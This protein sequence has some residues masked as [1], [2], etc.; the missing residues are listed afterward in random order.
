[1][2]S[3]LMIFTHVISLLQTINALALSQSTQSR[4]GPRNF[5][6][7]KR[8]NYFS[9]TALHSE[10]PSPNED[11]DTK[12]TFTPF[13]VSEGLWYIDEYTFEVKYC[14][15]PSTPE[16]DRYAIPLP[17]YYRYDEKTGR[18][19]F[20]QSNRDEEKEVDSYTANYMETAVNH[21]EPFVSILKYSRDYFINVINSKTPPKS[22]NFI[23]ESLQTPV[24]S[25]VSTD[26]P[27][28]PVP[29]VFNPGQYYYYPQTNFFY[30]ASDNTQ[31]RSRVIFWADPFLRRLF[32]SKKHN[33][34]NDPNSYVANARKYSAITCKDS[35]AQIPSLNSGNN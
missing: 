14:H 27:Q 8:D 35:R 21:A 23:V 34:L 9:A 6:F 33:I 32:K 5:S 18:Y 31:E 26:N 7:L 19:F 17:G 30:Y 22:L 28:K 3:I 10:T 15:D 29:I 11:S 20:K 25:Y 2:F 12:Y 4:I 24:K 1:M 13:M 16:I